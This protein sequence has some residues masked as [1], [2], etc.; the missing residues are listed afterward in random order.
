VAEWKMDEKTGTNAYDTSG[1]GNTGTLTLGPTWT[2]GK[3]GAAL[4]FDGNNDYVSA[5]PPVVGMTQGTMESWVKFDSLGPGVQ[6]PMGIGNAGAGK[7]RIDVYADGTAV[8]DFWLDGNATSA[9]G[10]IVAGVFYHLAATFDGT[11]KRMYV[12]GRQVA[13]AVSAVTAVNASTVQISGYTPGGYIVNGLIDHVRIFNYAR[14]PAQIAYDYN[15]GGPVGWWKMDECQGTVANDSGGL[16]TIG[17]IGGNPGTIT[18]G[19]TG[20]QT[21]VG[22]CTTAG[23]AWG[24]GVNG[25]YSNSLNFDGTDDYVSVG[26]PVPTSLQATTAITL[27]AWIKPAANGGSLLYQIVGSQYDTGGYRGATIFIDGRTSPV[28]KIHFQIGD[29]SGW[30][31]IEN[32]AGAYIAPLNVWTHV[33]AVWS[34]GNQGRVYFNGVLDSVIYQNA[35]SGSIGYSAGQ[36]FSIGRQNDASRYFNGKIDDV[37]IFNYAL[38]TT[39]VKTLYNAGAAVQF[40]PSTGSP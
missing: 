15:R 37:K 28:G 23:T 9:S 2:N 30:H 24:N 6:T 26:S 31:A 35:W 36:E 8:A 4:K 22:T 7:W 38:T 25:K 18:I 20:T 21:A 33:V 34:S 16:G 12:N 40:A 29:G 17:G 14:T 13:S 1:N 5:T 39:Q 3:V 27:A 32:P 19:A 11:T 10:V